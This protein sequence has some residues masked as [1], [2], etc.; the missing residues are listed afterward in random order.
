MKNRVLN[1]LIICEKSAE[2]RDH[3]ENILRV[4]KDYTESDLKNCVDED[5]EKLRKI[6][7]I[8]YLL[9][10]KRKDFFWRMNKI[11]QGLNYEEL[12]ALKKD[13]KN[14]EIKRNVNEVIKEKSYKK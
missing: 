3:H 9:E 12:S 4:I 8:K 10:Q 6:N 7:N 11:F 13:I 1:I 2:H 5:I 14:Y